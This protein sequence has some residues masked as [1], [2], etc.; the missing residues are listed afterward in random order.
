MRSIGVGFA[1]SVIAYIST[2]R[3][4]S[5]I[6]VNREKLHADLDSNWEV[7]AEPIQTVM[8]KY[9]VAWMSALGERTAMCV[10]GG[11]G[12]GTCN[13][14]MDSCCWSLGRAV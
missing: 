9:D 13:K 7:L 11:R 3:G 12:A 8:R 14:T 1:H 2:L 6:D 4:M 5:R 10:S